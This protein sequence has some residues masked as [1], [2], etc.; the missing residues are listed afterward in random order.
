MT[1]CGWRGHW[2][3]LGFF[4]IYY[5]LAKNVTL[6]NFDWLEMKDKKKFKGEPHKT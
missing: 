6:N 1:I 5:M 2:R 4:Y 3:Y